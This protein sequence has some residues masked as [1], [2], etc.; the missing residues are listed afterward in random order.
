M[1]LYVLRE[2][3]ILHSQV[4]YKASLAEDH[5]AFT[6]IRTKKV[7]RKKAGRIKTYRFAKSY[8][9][10]QTICVLEICISIQIIFIT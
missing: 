9:C 4:V 8:S 7:N 10:K 2:L 6:E 3:T 5:N 1:I